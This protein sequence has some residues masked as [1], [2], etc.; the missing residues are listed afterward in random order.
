VGVDDFVGVEVDVVRRRL[1]R[2]SDAFVVAVKSVVVFPPW[3]F[4][5]YDD[6]NDDGDGDDDVG[7]LAL[8]PP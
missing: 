7:L 4:V 1:V 8:D 2:G 5:S 3:T 6:N